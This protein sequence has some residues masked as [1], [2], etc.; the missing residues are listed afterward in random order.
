MRVHNKDLKKAY[1]W[2]AAGKNAKVIRFLEPKVPLFLDDP[3]Y[4][5]ILG[6]AC[7]E[8]GLIKDAATYL[9]RGLQADPSHLHV[10]LSLAVNHLKRKDPS[11]AVRIWLE[12][13]EDHPDDRNASRGLR[14]LKKL[15]DMEA[16]DKFLERLEVKRYLPVM[17]PLWSG[18][19]LLIMLLLF[20]LLA[21][22]YFRNELWGFVQS[23]SVTRRPGAELFM[24]FKKDIATGES[25]ALYPMSEGEVLRT[26]RKAL[27]HY[28]SYRD[29]SA[30][31]ELNRIRHSNVTEEIR[32]QVDIMLASLTESTLESI[33]TSFTY[34]EVSREPWLY[35]GCWV[36]WRG[37]TANVEFRDN[38]IN[39]DFLVGYEA[40]EVLDGRVPVTVPFLAVME[41]LPLE[42]LARVELS[43]GAFHLVAKTLYFLR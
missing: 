35:E 20:F 6:R 33:E 28:E 43:E 4:Y 37:V 19:I 11:S 27:K 22:V 3:N 41:P 12:I 5:A 17:K 38:A 15:S 16:Q 26:L 29:N 7:L 31:Y 39:F 10:R 1:R 21:G 14:A 13:L 32:Q 42:L 18:G 25:D 36:L 8:N 40:G 9:D 30:R 34:S 2:L 24:Q 23:L